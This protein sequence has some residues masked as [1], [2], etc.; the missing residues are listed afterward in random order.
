[1]LHQL[2]KEAFPPGGA[3]ERKKLGKF[4]RKVEGHTR[5]LQ[6]TQGTRN[7]PCMSHLTQTEVGLFMMHPPEA[8]ILLK[9]N[10]NSHSP[11]TRLR[12][13]WYNLFGPLLVPPCKVS[14]LVL[15]TPQERLPNTPTDSSLLFQALPFPVHLL[16]KPESL[17]EQKF[18][19]V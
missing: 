6:G 13:G 17:S 15:I 10:P 2:Q 7:V 1:M 5:T 4:F 16:N 9:S 12:L 14:T 18:L 11:Q 8:P 19:S 3:R